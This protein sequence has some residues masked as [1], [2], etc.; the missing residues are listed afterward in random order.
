MSHD[1][2]RSSIESRSPARAVVL[3]SGGGSNLQAFIDQI[4]EGKLPLEISLVISNI[5][6]AGGLQRALNAGI[7]TQVIEHTAFADRASFD[8]ALAERIDQE[9]PDL[10]ILAGFMRILTAEFVERYTNRLINIHPSLLP[11][12][13]GTN[14]HQRA[15]DA[16]E[17]WHG[18]SVHFVVPEVDAGPIIVQGR[19]PIG[20]TCSASELQT[21]VLGIEHQIYP[22]AAKW[23]AEGRLSV[24][25]DRIL[26]DGETST[27]QLQT[28]DL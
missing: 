8:T 15:I 12:F 21:R 25:E 28:Y 2:S 5:A 22:L 17:T 4:S 24:Q 16:K 7:N 23:F 18:A 6:G 9:Q 11:K 19:L 27:R 3:I 14:T 1:Q 10:I 20:E 13:P 26:L